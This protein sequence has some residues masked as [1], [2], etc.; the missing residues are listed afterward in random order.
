MK[1]AALQSLR[2]VLSERLEGGPLTLKE[3]G[4]LL[5]GAVER[6][7]Y[8]KAYVHALLNGNRPIIG[9]VA[10]AARVL[11]V[12]GAGLDERDWVDLLPTF[13][14]GPVGKLKAARA[15]GV[16]WA[17]LYAGDADVRAFVDALIDL[18]TRG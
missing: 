12:G 3:F 9:Q 13:E 16:P 4:R 14:G 5:G 17:E 6:K 1:S 10:R 18:I 15:E 2:N 7:P 11:M 8:S